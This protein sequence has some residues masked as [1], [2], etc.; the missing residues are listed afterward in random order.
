M[1]RR[2]ASVEDPLAAGMRVDKFISDVLGL[3]TRSQLKQRVVEVRVNGERAKLSRRLALGER[4]E[5]D[6]AEE[7]RLDVAPENIPLTIL[8]EDANVIVVDKPQGMV[9]HPAA[10]THSGTLV[11]ALAYHCAEIE[12]LL[13]SDN[14]RPG[15]V[16]RLDKDTSGVIIAAKSA[17]AQELLSRQFRRS[18]TEKVYLAIVKGRVLP[19]ADSISSFIRR[20]PDQRKRFVSDPKIGRLSETRYRVLRQWER[21]ALVA[22]RPRTGRTHQLRVHLSS[23]GHPILGDPIYGRPDSSFP[24]STLM[25]HAHRLSIVVP[26]SDG[27][28]RLTRAER[29]TFRSPLPERMKRVLRE[30]AA[31][32]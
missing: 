18:S 13:G 25:L 10:G 4:I 26:G 28:G 23:I 12:K 1:S 17:Q 27:E 5:V 3:C 31:R 19:I 22:L 8:F 15:I 32:A 11:Q 7:A 21:H 6:Y 16:H 20:D 9:V 14:L 2:S 30:L 24:G 29:V